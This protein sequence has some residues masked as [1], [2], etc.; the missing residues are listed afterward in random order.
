MLCSASSTRSSWTTSPAAA[1]STGI[2]PAAGRTVDIAI[3]HDPDGYLTFKTTRRRCKALYGV[4]Y[5]KNAY[6]LNLSVLK[7]GYT[8]VRRDTPRHELTASA[9]IIFLCLLSFQG[10]HNRMWPSIAELQKATGTHDKRMKETI[11]ANSVLRFFE[12]DKS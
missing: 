5:G 8:F 3:N 4:G 6:S 1:A 12:E 11:T 10:Q 7:R 2:E 9:F